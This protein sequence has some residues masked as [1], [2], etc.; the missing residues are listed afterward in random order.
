MTLDILVTMSFAEQ[1]HAY[2]VEHKAKLYKQ[3]RE[4]KAKRE[5]KPEHM[6]AERVK[7]IFEAN[8][9]I[10]KWITKATMKKYNIQQDIF[11]GQ[12]S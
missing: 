10:K 5:A 11:T 1:K 3:I 8:N 9:G 12:Y 2:Y 7:L 4:A 6:D